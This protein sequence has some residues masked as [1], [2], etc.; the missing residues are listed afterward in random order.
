MKVRM[1]PKDAGGQRKPDMPSVGNIQ[2][3]Y[4]KWIKGGYTVTQLPGPMNNESSIVPCMSCG[5]IRDQFI[6]ANLWISNGDTNSKI[7]KDS[8]NQMNCLYR[9]IKEWTLF[10][11]EHAKSLYLVNERHD[12]DQMYDT[13]GFSRV[14]TRDVNL[15]RYPKL[16]NVP[17]QK[18]RL[19]PGDCI[20]VPGTYIHHVYSSGERNIQVS[21]LFAGP[22]TPTAIGRV[23]G[24]KIQGSPFKDTID[25]GDTCAADGSSDSPLVGQVDVAWPF[26]GVGPITMGFA[27]PSSY[28][29]HWKQEVGRRASI[30]QQDFVQTFVDFVDDMDPCDDRTAAWGDDLEPRRHVL[31]ALDV[32]YPEW[33]GQHDH[34]NMTCRRGSCRIPKLCTMLSTAVTDQASTL[35]KKLAGSSQTMKTTLFTQKSRRQLQDAMVSLFVRDQIAAIF[36]EVTG[37]YGHGGDL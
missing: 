21:M 20:F 17:F 28:V 22:G 4:A 15:N 27:N 35:F 2:N 3:F 29:A 36:D 16:A 12:L 32:L 7:H 14:G 13:A 10:P 25:H 31:E 33:S 30:S 24:K 1:E 6:E 34:W 11:P 19:E 18:A 8:N 23:Y 26:D 37:D 5:P 9:G